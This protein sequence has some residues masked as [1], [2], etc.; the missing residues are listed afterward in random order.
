MRKDTRDELDFAGPRNADG[1]AFA[2][3]GRV[4]AGMDV[5]RC[6][7]AAPVREKTQ[8]LVPPAIRILKAMVP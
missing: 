5:V 1:Q 6:I 4:A 2:V 7:Q 3:F 8:N